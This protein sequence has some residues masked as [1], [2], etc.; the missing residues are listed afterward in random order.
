MHRLIW[1]SDSSS[2]RTRLD[3]GPPRYQ[4]K[5]LCLLASLLLVA[6][7]DHKTPNLVL[8]SIYL[9]PVMMMMQTKSDAFKIYFS[10]WISHLIKL[11]TFE[12]LV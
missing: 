12:L 5:N 8:D 4:T 10:S 2:E 9:T 7:D 6:L 11:F 1:F 3:P